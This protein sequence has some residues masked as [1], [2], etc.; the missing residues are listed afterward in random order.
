MQFTMSLRAKNPTR[1]CPLLPCSSR[2]SNKTHLAESDQKQA[3]RILAG[4]HG[5]S[6]HTPLPRFTGNVKRPWPQSPKRTTLHQG[7]SSRRKQHD[8]TPTSQRTNNFCYH[9]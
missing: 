3:L 5:G 4:T 2:V 8:R 1:T 6:S 9:L 7:R